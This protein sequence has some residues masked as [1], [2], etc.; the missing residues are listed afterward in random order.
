M[1]IQTA[2][3]VRHAI[4]TTMVITVTAQLQVAFI[5]MFGFRAT[6]ILHPFKSPKTWYRRAISPVWLSLKEEMVDMTF[7]QQQ[8]P[9]TTLRQQLHIK[10]RPPPLHLVG[11]KVRPRAH[12]I[13]Q[14]KFR[15]ARMLHL[16]FQPLTNIYPL[17]SM[18][19][20]ANIIINPQARPHHLDITLLV[21]IPSNPQC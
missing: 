13:L 21:Q 10:I 9:P 15:G 3:L 18:I 17:L 2:L 11:I 5:T 12:H 8:R 7:R 16:Q 4:M 20:R 19:P 1:L 14:L 6:V